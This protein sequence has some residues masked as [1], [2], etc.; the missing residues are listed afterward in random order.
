M[1]KSSMHNHTDLCD[2]NNTPEEMALD[3]IGLGFTDF[4]FSGHSMNMKY[5]AEWGLRDEEIFI[6]EINRLKEKY[7]GK[8]NIYLGM[9]NDYFGRTKNLDRL[10]YVITS[11]HGF[12]SADD[13][14]CYSIDNGA[15]ELIRGIDKVYSGKAM[16]MIKAYYDNLCKAVM[17][18]KSDIIGHLDLPVKHNEGNLIFNEDSNEY[19]SIAKEAIKVLSP[20]SVFEVNTGGMY[21]GYRNFPYPK[22]ELL[23]YIL[24]EGGKVTISADAHSIESIDYMFDEMEKLVKDVGFKDIYI[25][26]NGEFKKHHL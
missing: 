14:M 20:L 10:D 8:I 13:T 2:G 17:V 25:Y 9:E 22:Q 24:K 3:A 19:L 12:M 15:E 21:R 5:F 23:Y 1:I 26:E 4:G 18:D 16:N 11:V 6:N 7:K